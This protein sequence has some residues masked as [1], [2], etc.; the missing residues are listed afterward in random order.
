MIPPTFRPTSGAAATILRPME[1]QRNRLAPSSKAAA[2]W[3]PLTDRAHTP[4]WSSSMRHTGS[5]TTSRT[6]P[7]RFADAGYVA[8]AVDLFGGRNRAVCMARYMT[9][10][11]RGSVNRYGID[12]LKAA[13]TLPGGDPHVDPAR[14]GA[15]GFCMGGGFAIAW[16]CTDSRL[17]A[18]A[19]FY[20]ANPR[21]LEAVS[22][23][24][25]WSAPIPRRTSPRARDEPWTRRSR[26][27]GITRDI[28]IYPGAGHSFFNDKGRAYNEA[29]A[30]DSWRRVL[31]FFGEQLRP[32]AKR[33]GLSLHRRTAARARRARPAAPGREPERGASV[34]RLHRPALAIL[35]AAFV[36]QQVGV[37]LADDRRALAAELDPR[38]LVLRRDERERTPG[39]AHARG[40]SDAVGQ[41]LRRVRQL[42]V[43]DEADVGHVDPP[44]GHV[45][46][47]ED[48]AAAIAKRIHRPIADQLREVALQ[49]DR[50][51]PQLPK[52]VV[53]LLDTVLGATEDDRAFPTWRRSSLLSVCSL[54]SRSTRSNPCSSARHDRS[55]ACTCT[56][57]CVCFSTML[58][59]QLGIVAEASTVCG[60]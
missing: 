22:R 29:A 10:M 35:P 17:K 16:A 23:L 49:L 51:V 40:P 13:L 57:S 28:K 34:P 4:A 56:G 8:L 30:E 5:T 53:Q 25:R 38:R 58:V 15:I 39:L 14:V 48:L 37:E 19:P 7:G 9:G 1:T 21:P 45:G 12:E 32:D 31:S 11:L 3:P 47:D 43:D 55:R 46:R 24:V 54:C 59:T 44:R 60:S 18:I 26:S 52:A 41:P 50:V 42:E 6:S 36:E 2:T 27:H 20:G 33:F